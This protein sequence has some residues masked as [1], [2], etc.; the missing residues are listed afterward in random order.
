MLTTSTSK[1]GGPRA[2]V[3]RMGLVTRVN[4]V[5]PGRAPLNIVHVALE[6]EEES[7]LLPLSEEA[8]MQLLAY[9]LKT[10]PKRGHRK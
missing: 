8:A 10:L 1:D 2:G 4:G 7:L 6:G 5:E 9:L 3:T